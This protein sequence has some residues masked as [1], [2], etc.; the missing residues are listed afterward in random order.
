MLN[1]PG[2]QPVTGSEG[3]NFQSFPPPQPAPAG[4]FD[5][6]ALQARINELLTQNQTLTAQITDWQSRYNGQQGAIQREVEAKKNAL[7]QANELQTQFASLQADLQSKET[8]WKTQLD[9]LNQTLNERTSKLSGY[10]KKDATRTF[11]SASPDFKDLVSYF[12]QG[13]MPGVESM[14]GDEQTAFLTKFKTVTS[15][16]REGA[17]VNTLL[18]SSPAPNAPAPSGGASLTVDELH[19]QMMSMNPWDPK[20]QEYDKQYSQLLAAQK[21]P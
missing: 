20:Y 10:E 3:S 4:Q 7:L 21:K 18:G 6:G 12:D 2:Q 8:H 14:E 13:L 17:V 1:Q 11:L 16:L 9:T 15:Q 5:V 19:Q